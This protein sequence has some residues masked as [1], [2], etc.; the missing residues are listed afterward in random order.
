MTYNISSIN[1][2]NETFVLSTL[3]GQGGFGKVYLIVDPKN[4]NAKYALKLMNISSKN[5][6]EKINNEY[7]TNVVLKR[8]KQDVSNAIK[9]ITQAKQQLS[10]CSENNVNCF[11]DIGKINNS[12]GYILMDY[13]DSDYGKIIDNMGVYQKLRMNKLQNQIFPILDDHLNFMV[14]FTKGV[15]YIHNMNIGHGDIKPGNML[16]KLDP[17]NYKN[18]KLVIADFDTVCVNKSICNVNSYTQLYAQPSLYNKIAANQNNIQLQEVIKTDMWALNMSYLA[19]WF[20]S[21]KLFA[22]FSCQSDLAQKIPAKY[23]NNPNINDGVNVQYDKFIEQTINGTYISDR[24]EMYNHFNNPT[25]MTYLFDRLYYELTL[26]FNVLNLD[27]SLIDKYKK[28]MF[29]AFDYLI[30]NQ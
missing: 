20:S 28:I 14:Q 5:Q 21:N 29:A 2:L 12:C 10:N 18:N 17:K 22:L 23:S 15:Q 24:V 7:T 1:I 16:V 11:I 13:Y 25:I 3:I 26:S 8:N 6:I 19:T 27:P 9:T 4:P 30:I